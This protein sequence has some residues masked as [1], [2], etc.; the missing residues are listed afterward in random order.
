MVRECRRSSPRSI[1]Q[2]ARH[3]PRGEWIDSLCL[4]NRAEEGEEEEVKTKK[5]SAAPLAVCYSCGPN[6]CKNHAARSTTVR[7][8]IFFGCRVDFETGGRSTRAS[9]AKLDLSFPTF[10]QT[11]P[12]ARTHDR[13][14]QRRWHHHYHQLR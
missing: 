9:W 12:T 11:R 2:N 4:R 13:P 1:H 7:F 5:M 14:N 10:V 6:R 8:W 3:V